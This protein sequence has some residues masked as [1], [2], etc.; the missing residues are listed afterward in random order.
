MTDANRTDLA[1]RLKRLPGRPRCWSAEAAAGSAKVLVG[2]A[3]LIPGP[4]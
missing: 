4:P 3:A 2:L 1:D